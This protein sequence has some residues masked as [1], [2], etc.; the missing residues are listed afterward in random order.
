MD[1]R[2]LAGAVFSSALTTV[3]FAQ[4]TAQNGG[5]ADAARQLEADL[6]AA[7]ATCRSAL[8]AAVTDAPTACAEVVALTERLAPDRRLERRGA[9]RGLASAF[10]LNGRFAEARVQME[11]AIVVSG[12]LDINAEAADDYRDLAMIQVALKDFPSADATFA[13]AVR[14]YETAI[15]A[16]GSP[17]L[18]EQYRSRLQ[19]TLTEYIR[20]K[21]SQGD[22]AGAMALEAKLAPRPPN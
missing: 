11:R 3:L 4:T 10:F 6:R 22:T 17:G 15:V 12:L 7:N 18:A 19:Q 20:F 2:F 5:P 13:R 21:R 14:I 8:Q 1:T 9:L 16:I